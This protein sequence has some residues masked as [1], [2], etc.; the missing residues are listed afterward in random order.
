MKQFQI[1]LLF[2][3]STLLL[4]HITMACGMSADKKVDSE[5]SNSSDQQQKSCCKEG[6]DSEK[7]HKNCSNTCEQSCC[8]CATSSASSSFNF[9][10][11]ASFKN[12]NPQFFL[13]KETQFSY[14][15]K[16]ISDGFLSIW[17]IPK[18]G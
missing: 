15:A 5:I 8:N 18:I 2:L 3:F 6:S 14:I 16:P 10:T 12:T 13:I 9:T 4:P 7:D 17:L 11:E 1:L